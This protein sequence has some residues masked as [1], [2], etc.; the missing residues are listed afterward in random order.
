MDFMV[1]HKNE[2]SF[3]INL[4]RPG[5]RCSVQTAERA[6]STHGAFGGPSAAEELGDSSARAGVWKGFT[7]WRIQGEVEG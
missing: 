2:W 5:D 1:M 4:E 3:Q 6:T 7:Q